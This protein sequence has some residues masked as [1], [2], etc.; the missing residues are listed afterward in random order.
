MSKGEKRPIPGT[1]PAWKRFL[2]DGYHNS[3]VDRD[4]KPYDN[5]WNFDEEDDEEKPKNKNA[6]WDELAKKPEKE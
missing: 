3:L 1:N 5:G 4:G 2:P 6:G